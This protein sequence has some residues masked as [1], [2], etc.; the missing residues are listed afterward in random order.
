MVEARKYRCLAKE[1]FASLLNKLGWEGAVVLNF[2][3]G[4]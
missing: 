1:L 4:A 3:Y 2:F